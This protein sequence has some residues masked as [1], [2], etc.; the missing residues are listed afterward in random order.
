M[1]NITPKLL[2]IGNTVASN[3]Y[4]VSNTVGN[5][6]I[7]KSVNA[8]NTTDVSNATIS[9]HIL[10]DGAAPSSNNKIL[11]NANVIKNDVLYYNTSIVIPANS[12]LYVSSTSSTITFA[13]SGVEYA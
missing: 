3:V 8:C 2:Y 5:Y 7:I 10:K 9:I 1:A 6:S 11:S 12:N 4:S 13:I